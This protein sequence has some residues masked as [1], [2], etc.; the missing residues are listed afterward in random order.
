MHSRL[1]T[2]S[3]P[4]MAASTSET[5]ELGAPPNAVAAPENSLDCEATWAWTSRPITTSQSPVA[6][7]ISFDFFAGAFISRLPPLR[8]RE[9][10]G[11]V[12][13]HL[14]QREQRLLVERAAD[15]LQPERQAFRR[16][17]AGNRKTGQSRHVHGHREHVVE[18]HF[19]RIPLA[20]HADREGG[21][22]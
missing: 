1:M 9:A 11:G 8:R 20:F 22:G 7:R 4:G 18:V 15:E 14:R 5:W 3:M 21:P 6:P 12:F 10:A 16:Q 13:D 2:G 19:Y 17:A